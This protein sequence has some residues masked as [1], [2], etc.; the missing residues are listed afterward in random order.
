MYNLTACCKSICKFVLLLLL[1]ISAGEKSLAQCPVNID[2]E[3]GTFSGWQC[4]TGTTYVNNGTNV[5]NLVPVPAAIPGRHTMLSTIPGN[6]LDPFANFPMNCPNGSGHSIKLG[7]QSGGHEAE[8]VSYTFTIPNGQNEFNIV[9]NYAVVFQGPQHQN[10]EQPRLVIE[11]MNLTDNVRIDCSSFE[12]YKS[13]N[14][15]L[16]GFFLAP[17]NNTGT[18]IW[19]KN[20]SS[21]S[22]KLDSYA[23]KT[24]QI[25]F[26]TADCTFNAHFG[27]A[28]V[29][30]ST[31]CSSSFVGAVYC[32]DDTAVNVTAPYGYETYQWWD[33]ADPT[34]T[35]LATTQTIRFSPPPMAGSIYNV[36]VTPYSGYGCNDVFSAKM[37]DTLTI[38]SVAGRDTISCQ[39][40]P[41]QLGTS[42]RQGYVYS[43]NPTTGLSNPNI[44]NPIAT[45]SVTTQYVVT[46]SHE[47]G[48]CISTDTV[49]VKAAVLDNSLQIT[50]PVT[51]CITAA[52]PSLL[53]VNT[54]DSIQWYRNGN[55]IPGANGT[56]Y[57]VL[58]SGDYNATLFS[59]QGC[60]LSTVVT[61]IT[62]N[63]LPAAG[64]TPDVHIQ[65]FKNHQF[66]F[67]NSSTIASGTMQYLWDL[68]D[69]TTET[70]MDVT[71]SYLLPG[72]YEVKLIVTSDNGCVDSLKDSVHVFDS[73]LAGFY[74]VNANNQ[75]FKNHQYVFNNTS[76]IGNGTMKYVWDLGDGTTA[77]TKDVTHAYTL[78][79]SYTVKLSVTSDKGC[80]AESAF[81]VFVN[82]EPVVGF[83]EPN[84]QQCFTNNQF[85]FI[86][87]SNISTG[88]LQYLWTL[89]DGTTETTKDVTHSYQSSGTFVVKL[90]ASSDK[91]CVDSTTQNFSIFPFA[92]AD[93]F[94]EPICVNLPL[95]LVNKTINN[96]AI[97]LNYLWDFGNGDGS[98]FKSPVYK[99]PAAGTYSIS[100]SVNTNQCPQTITT[101]NL[102]VVIDAP[103]KGITYSEKDAVM[104]FAEQLQARN[105]GTT[106]YWSPGTSLDTRYSYKPVFKGLNEQLYTI[107]L[108]TVS[109]CLT[110][111]TQL[112]KTHKKIAIYVPTIF[113]PNGDGVNDYLRPNLLSFMK[114]NYFRVFDRWGKMVY[115]MASDRPGW[116]GRVNGQKQEMQTYVWMI[117]AVDVDGTIHKEQ[118][119]TILIR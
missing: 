3:Q 81:D 45:P 82:P 27:Y 70:T 102:I 7:N 9:Y 15:T 71:H 83:S 36:A 72:D 22:I 62:V 6:G 19:C 95:P 35:I 10:Y 21:A 53:K 80:P 78:P 20:W 98:T 31:E 100:L 103:A 108:K 64:F 104:N 26:K 11:V 114:V 92:K 2:F 97:N 91:G 60:N 73:P 107:Q 44:A 33:N 66:V 105:I 57:N 74:N 79:G 23:G 117:E 12:F 116:D 88:S 69:G 99:Y 50:G 109:G 38:Q 118:G 42:S 54:A 75:C 28:Y 30:V 18:P 89:G 25:F 65:C 24:I 94:V 68:G 61:T 14:S 29:D 59:F 17:N 37:L 47:G 4:W 46:T 101:K 86:N 40:A 5:I 110:V 8:G 87:S 113:T 52:N 41:V 16:P 58:Q 76:T 112:V 48:G 84:A 67:T 106:A 77:T 43:W 119:T 111:D 39:N 96:T 51:G 13:I 63:P 90:V 85:N 34:Q 55:P 1:T 93:F 115:Q 56:Q 32:P 49:I